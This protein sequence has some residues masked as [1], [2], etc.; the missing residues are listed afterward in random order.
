MP[1]YKLERRGS[2]YCTTCEKRT[3]WYY[4]T[5]EY[6]QETEGVTDVMFCGDCE[7]NYVQSQ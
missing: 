7:L 5:T 4:G 3:F 2:Q 6:L 1:Q